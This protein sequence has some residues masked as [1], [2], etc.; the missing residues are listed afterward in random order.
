M[1]PRACRDFQ[2][3]FR[4]C[5]ERVVCQGLGIKGSVSSACPYTS[6]ARDETSTPLSGSCAAPLHSRPLRPPKLARCPFPAEKASES[7][8]RVGSPSRI[9]A[10][11]LRVEC[12]QSLGRSA[13]RLHKAGGESE[14]REGRRPPAAPCRVPP[15]VHGQTTDR[16]LAVRLTMVKMV[17]GPGDPATREVEEYTLSGGWEYSRWLGGGG[18][19]PGDSD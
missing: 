6:R 10:S 19:I 2:A 14:S 12:V 13:A 7:D 16:G 18:Q 11:N 3:A 15:Q 9:S 4:D 1:L 17:K 5:R 8:L